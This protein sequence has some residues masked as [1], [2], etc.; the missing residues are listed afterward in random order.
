MLLKD[1]PVKVKAGPDDGLGEGQFSAYA[2]VFGNV[3]SYGDVSVLPTRDY[4]YGLRAGDDIKL[5]GVPGMPAGATVT[6]S[7]QSINDY[8]FTTWNGQN[9]WAHREWLQVVSAPS[10][11]PST[12]VTTDALNMR[13]GAGLSLADLVKSPDRASDPSRASATIVAVRSDR[14]GWP[15]CALTITGAPAARARADADSAATSCGCGSRRSR[16]FAPRRNVPT[17]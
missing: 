5:A 14:R 3:D 17:V 4:L 10:E 9:G 13:T 7:G 6:L 11:S 16:R 12:A 2:S 15:E 8:L 1:M